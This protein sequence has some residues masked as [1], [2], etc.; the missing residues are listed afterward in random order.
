MQVCIMPCRMAGC[1]IITI[2]P[3]F[4]H[5]LICMMAQL[6]SAS[7]RSLSFCCLKC[8]MSTHAAFTNS[9][10]GKDTAFSHPH[11]NRRS[12][13]REILM[14]RYEERNE[15]REKALLAL[16]IL[17]FDSLLPL[18]YLLFQKLQSGLPLLRCL[19]TKQLTGHPLQGE[20][21]HGLRLQRTDGWTALSNMKRGCHQ[22]IGVWKVSLYIFG[23]S[24]MKVIISL[25]NQ[26]LNKE[27]LCLCVCVEDQGL[28]YTSDK[29]LFLLF[30]A[31]EIQGCHLQLVLIQF[32][33]SAHCPTQIQNVLKTDPQTNNEFA[34]AKS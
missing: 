28:A 15:C 19:L 33:F 27:T 30:L 22:Y 7:F 31:G 20:R 34:Q 16:C 14:K 13:E 24:I 26:G 8:S 32:V 18:V 5:M 25:F 6:M 29:L 9:L 21:T 3:T 12:E 10:R 4:L 11:R 17:F 23:K 1:V 2:R